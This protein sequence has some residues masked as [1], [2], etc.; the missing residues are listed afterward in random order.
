[1]TFYGVVT[2]TLYIAAIDPMAHSVSGT[3]SYTATDGMTVVT[4]TNG[5]F[6]ITNMTVTP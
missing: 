4:V 3:F 6:N 5:Q 2:G 1:M